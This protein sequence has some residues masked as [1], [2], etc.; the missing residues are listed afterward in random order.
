MKFWKW[1]TNLFDH[2]PA[3]VVHDFPTPERT[4]ANP[5]P[6]VQVPVVPA[7]K[8]SDGLSRF[9]RAVRYVM[10]NEDG[11]DYAHDR[12]GFTNDARDPGG[13]TMW[14]I[15]KTEYEA[16]LVQNLTVEQVSQMPRSTAE[17][18][19][20]KKF[21]EVIRGDDYDSEA[22]ATAI[23][24]T[25]VNK[26]LGGCHTILQ[27]ALG[28][29]VS[30]YGQDCVDAVNNEQPQRFMV[31]FEDALERYIALRI[32]QYPSMIWAKNG[33]MNRAKRLLELREPS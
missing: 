22:M 8:Q 31:R 12:G 28:K 15:I 2:G 11:K 21:W 26:G 4:V 17:A 1:L 5:P 29:D 13:A 9:D 6:V 10:M 16:A 30:R 24:D 18:I 20:R 3:P 33:W 19:Y 32:Q 25:A 7:P 23:F 27:N 14:G